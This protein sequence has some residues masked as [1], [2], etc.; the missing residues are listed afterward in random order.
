[1]KRT[2]LSLVATALMSATAL[3]ADIKPAILF[4]LGGKF[5]KSF[6]E[7]AFNGAKQFQE[8]TGIEFREFEI[9]NAAQR[10]QA[11]RRF[12]RDGNNPITMAGF[13]WAEPLAKVAPDYPDINFAIIDMVVEAPNVR[14]VVFKEQEGSYLVGMMAAMSSETG[15]VSFVGG[16]D[17][18]LIRRF[19][20]GYTAGA[21]DGKDGINVIQTMTGTTPAAW[22]N[23]IKGAEITKSHID[24]GSDVVFQAAGGTGIAV[25]QAAADGDIL[26]IGVDSNQNGMHPGKVLTSMVKRVDVAV[27]N[28]FMDAKNDAFT[29]GFNSLG[30]AEDGVG[31]ALDDNNASLVSAEMK[32]AVEAAKADIVSGKLVIHDYMSDNAC[33]Y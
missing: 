4:D 3:A 31:Y 24:Q 28:T 2:L 15:T 19:A 33:P 29:Y 13:Q 22:N 8:E 21:K 1:M 18:P 17:V 26:G 9:S 11:I 7:A 32:A 16:M 6:N 14:S 23:Q 10:E 5:D 20:C 30:L 25:L 27:Y 12:A